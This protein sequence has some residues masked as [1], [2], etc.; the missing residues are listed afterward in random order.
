MRLAL[1]TSGETGT[2]EWVDIAGLLVP[3]EE[4]T[5]LIDQIERGAIST[6]CVM[7][8]TFRAWKEHHEAWTWNWA[9]SRLQREAA[10]DVRVVTACRLV[11]FLGE[12]K[13][14]VVTL[15]RLMYEDARKEFTL[16]SRVGFG[17]DGTEETRHSDFE[18]VRGEFDD[19]PAV[20]GILDHIQRK[21][22]LYDA[23]V[24]KIQTI[25]NE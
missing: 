10:I 7:N 13:E 25:K 4:V 20:R 22:D 5:R 17:I 11:E 9:A 2:G 15:D 23:L 24:K 1:A 18:Q 16:K 21:G 14:A 8:D 6:P 12:W 3:E 19:H